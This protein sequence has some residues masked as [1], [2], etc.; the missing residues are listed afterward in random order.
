MSTTKTVSVWQQ[1]LDCLGE[2]VVWNVREAITYLLIRRI[3]YPISR[4]LLPV[5]DPGA[6]KRAVAVKN[7]NRTLWKLLN[8]GSNYR[9]T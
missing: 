5:F 3:K 4:I 6:T 1:E 2:L 8:H 9:L 7:K